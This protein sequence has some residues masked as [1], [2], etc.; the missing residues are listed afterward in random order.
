MHC[1][2]FNLVM[3]KFFK[4]RNGEN[5]FRDIIVEYEK[6]VKNIRK[7]KIIIVF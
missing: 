2:D 1:K 4:G 6:K 3:P 7:N 5:F